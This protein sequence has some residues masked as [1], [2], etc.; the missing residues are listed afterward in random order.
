M[1]R[2]DSGLGWPQNR[3][4]IGAGVVMTLCFAAIAGL[5]RLRGAALIPFLIYFVGAGIAYT[6]A[7]YWIPRQPVSVRWVWI[8]ALL[9]RLIILFNRPPT[10][11]DDVYRYIWDGRLVNAAVSPYAHR[12]DS[13]LLDQ[14]ASPQREL[15]NNA[16][17]A[18]PYLPAAQ[19][20][21]AA[22]YGLAPDS[23]FAFQV[24]AVGLDLLAGWLLTRILFLLGLPR[25]RAIIYLWNPLVILEFAHGAHIDA[26][27]LVLVMAALWFLV[28]ER[29]RSS[30]RPSQKSSPAKRLIPRI[31]GL[32]SPALL[33]AATLTKGVPALLVPVLV[34]RWGWRRALFCVSL[35]ILVLVP[36]GLDAGW[37]LTGPL[38]G[39]GLFGAL[40]IYATRWNYNGGLYH[41]LEVVLSGY[42]T[43]GAV[44]PEFVGEAPIRAARL[45]V[46]GALLVTVLALA[47]RARRCDDDLCLLR[48]V[49]IVFAAYLLLS[50][51]VHP[52]YVTIVVPFLPFWVNRTG[53]EARHHR[54][55]W[56]W[57][58]F[59]TAVSLS[60]LTY[61]DP[62][63][64]REYDWV[65]LIQYG[66]LYALLI[67]SA[68]PMSDDAHAS[69]SD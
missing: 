13:S 57:L 15:V 54:F 8:F 1:N 68:W 14:L 31:D 26:L 37:G 35:I 40:R 41:W 25:A 56:P 43:P 61:L 34:W 9:F 23:P 36:I 6:I 51:T 65:R 44:P 63:N 53:D 5:P 66:P 50:T 2:Q 7:V 62:T 11:S 39:E 32:A 64:L 22:V 4:L 17:M 27:M 52:W 18:S 21:F 30:A 16:W 28:R 38:D 45:I 12:V 19:A 29:R 20:V 48:M 47:R 55:L 46:S 24:A 10:L 42:P 58:F 60:Y 67:W 69:A 49:T 3:P 33:A 59:S